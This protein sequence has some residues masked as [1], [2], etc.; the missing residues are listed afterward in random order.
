M[1][2]VAEKCIYCGKPIIHTKWNAQKIY[3]S[4][5]CKRLF[6]KEHFTEWQREHRKKKVLTFKT[7]KV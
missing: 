7:G 2:P 5:L 4:N 3:C 1:Q 6:N